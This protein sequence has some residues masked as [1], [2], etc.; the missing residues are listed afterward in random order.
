MANELKLNL[1]VDDKLITDTHGI[2][3]I[4]PLDRGFGITLG[5]A[6]RRVLPGRGRHQEQRAVFPPGK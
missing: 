4:Q 6:L 1:K 3:S 2:F 5:N